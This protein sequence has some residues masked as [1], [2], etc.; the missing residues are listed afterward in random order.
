MSLYMLYRH[1]MPRRWSTPCVT[2]ST[3]EAII[4]RPGF[5]RAVV[6]VAGFH[7]QPRNH[8]SLA[9]SYPAWIGGR[10]FPDGRSCH[11]LPEL[12]KTLAGSPFGLPIRD[13]LRCPVTGG[14]RFAGRTAFIPFGGECQRCGVG[15]ATQANMRLSTGMAYSL[16]IQNHF[17]SKP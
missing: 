14:L 12:P 16:L 13:G 2:R 10:H 4:S 9:I 3:P 17:W 6:H 8:W 5:L 15:V 1:R 11:C 7:R